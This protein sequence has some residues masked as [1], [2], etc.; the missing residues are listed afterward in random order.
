M[1][2]QTFPSIDAAVG[3]FFDLD[4]MLLSG[5]PAKLETARSWVAI[6]VARGVF[7]LSNNKYE[8]YTQ[9]CNPNAT[10]Y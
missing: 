4:E 6:H 9:A 10:T 2:D 8:T 1:D 7:R 5:D 3:H